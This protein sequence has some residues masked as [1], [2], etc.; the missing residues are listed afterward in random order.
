[1]QFVMQPDMV[2]RN[3]LWEV[4]LVS[5]GLAALGAAGLELIAGRL[6]SVEFRRRHNDATAAI[7]SVVGFTFGCSSHL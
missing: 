1:M 2:Y 5:V 3:P 7:F 6:L 4:G